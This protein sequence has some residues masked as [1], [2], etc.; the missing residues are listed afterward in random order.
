MATV[1]MKTLLEAGVHFGHHT[2]R[3]NPKMRRFIFA[4]RNG[5]HILDLQQTVHRLQSACEFLRDLVIAGENVLFVGTKK[6]AQETIEEEAKRAGQP[7][8]NQRWLGGQ[9]TNWQTI[10]LRI[11][12]LQ[13]LKYQKERGEF[14]LLPKKEAVK[15][16]EQIN[17]LQRIFGGIETMRDLPGAVYIVDT[18]HEHIAVAEA[19]RLGIPIVAL[20]DSN[21]DP[22][23]IDWPIPAND[24][25]IRAIRL[26]TSHIAEACSEGFQVRGAVSEDEAAAELGEEEDTG[27]GLSELEEEYVPAA[28]QEAGSPL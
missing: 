2:R 24:D 5:I 9:L 16:Q 3:W 25:A 12:Y 28:E 13:N 15:L 11:Q 27:I 10:Q 20:V 19:R 4:E 1:S 17:R 8:I 23:E 21:C 6:Q 14:E 18:K 26:I 7:Y 22:T